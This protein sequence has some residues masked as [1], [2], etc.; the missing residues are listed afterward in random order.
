M[1]PTQPNG[2]RYTMLTRPADSPMLLD[3]G[4]PTPR[5]ALLTTGVTLAFLAAAMLAALLV[6]AFTPKSSLDEW[7]PW[8]AIAAGG[9]TLI[10][11]YCLMQAH[12]YGTVTRK[13]WVGYYA[14]LE[15]WHNAVLDSYV[16]LQGVET[17]QSIDVYSYDPSVPHHVLLTALAVHMQLTNGLGTGRQVPFSVRALDGSLMLGSNDRNLV[18][19]GELN[20]TTPE[21]MANA[22]AAV[23]LIR[24][25]RNNY[26]GT[27]TANTLED[28]VTTFLNNWHKVGRNSVRRSVTDE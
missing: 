7:T 24:D 10:A 20:G 4:K 11:V 9:C 22:L 27:W 17:V 21:K 3:A 26:A 15:E 1:L 6:Y 23:G 13:G 25:R 14:R 19:I 12:A 28:V 16:N 2:A 5:E 8:G 18:R